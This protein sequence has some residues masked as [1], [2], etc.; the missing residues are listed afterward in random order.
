MGPSSAQPAAAA[1]AQA[2]PLSPIIRSAIRLL[3]AG[4]EAARSPDGPGSSPA[5]DVLHSS[6]SE[7]S[8]MP[9]L[10]DPPADEPHTDDPIVFLPDV[11]KA[12]DDVE[13]MAKETFA[14]EESLCSRGA[15]FT[16][17]EVWACLTCLAEAAG[18][19]ADTPT[20]IERR[21]NYLCDACTVECHPGHDVRSL[22]Y[23]RGVRCDCDD[24]D[25]CPGQKCSLLADLSAKP[26]ARRPVASPLG[27]L[28]LRDPV[29]N[30]YTLGNANRFCICRRFYSEDDGPAA[31]GEADG[32]PDAAPADEDDIMVQCVGCEDWLHGRCVARARGTDADSCPA[33]PWELLAST[34]AA[35]LPAAGPRSHCWAYFLCGRC[36]AGD[37]L[38]LA[39]A[40]R[41]APDVERVPL[42]PSY[43]VGDN[44]PSRTPSPDLPL[45][46]RTAP[47]DLD[48]FRAG[49]HGQ[50]FHMLLPR[51][52]RKM[53]CGC[54]LC[55]ALLRQGMDLPG[56]WEGPGPESVDWSP[57][58][59]LLLGPV[60]GLHTAGPGAGDEREEAQSAG[61][62]AAARPARAA[63]AAAVA[64]AHLRSGGA[65]TPAHAPEQAHAIAQGIASLHSHLRAELAQL[66]ADSV[67]TPEIIRGIFSRLRRE[68]AEE[69]APAAK[70]QRGA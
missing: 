65:G 55:R 34:P 8:D 6:D 2:S 21:G 17:Q 35:A 51:T 56:H 5:I 31:P 12:I 47:A 1:A 45:G 41:A 62:G 66:P 46:C 18:H 30:R 15:G 57:L 9:S 49:V 63:V 4:D 61:A 53:V 26:A 3:A 23:R 54:G 43:L 37:A 44:S 39:W 67:V 28:I 60:A 50:P 11:I 59:A 19:G 10:V 36:V 25:R 22:G 27:D 69:G 38:P 32:A 64:P 70:R 14:R 58:A 24:P 68:G 20:A 42:D 7:G 13:Q 52:F 40:L 48:D 16:L 33:G 29:A